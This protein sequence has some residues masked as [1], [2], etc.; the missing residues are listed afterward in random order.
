[1]Q[2]NSTLK[3]RWSLLLIFV[4]LSFYLFNLCYN[5]C[6][7]YTNSAGIRH[8]GFGIYTYAK[9]SPENYGGFIFPNTMLHPDHSAGY[10]VE[11][12][13][14]Q[15]NSTKN[16]FLGFL[17]L[18]YVSLL[19]WLLLMNGFFKCL[20]PSDIFTES[21]VRGIKRIFHFSGYLSMLVFASGF[22]LP[23]IVS[24]ILGI[25]V[26]PSAESLE[27]ILILILFVL[28][29]T[30]LMALGYYFNNGYRLKT[31]QALTI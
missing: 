31:E 28:F 29:N 19:V 24:R 4:I 2:L 18:W 22:V 14:D 3:I 1:M 7:P 30:I 11:C 9:L 12:G 26:F 23:Q 5:I 15:F 25:Y 21:S 6:Y 10:M 16:L 20:D 17:L 8:L 13:T 27:F